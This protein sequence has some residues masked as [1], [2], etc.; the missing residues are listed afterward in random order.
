MNLRGITSVYCYEK[1]IW[2]NFGK[3]KSKLFSEEICSLSDER[4]KK[5]Y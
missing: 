1:W 3:Y 4:K 2:N 5:V